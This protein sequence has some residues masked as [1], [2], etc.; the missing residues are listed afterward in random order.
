VGAATAQLIGL[1]GKRKSGTRGHSSTLTQIGK[2]ASGAVL[3]AIAMN[4]VSE[5]LA[6]HKNSHRYYRD[7]SFSTPR[8]SQIKTLA[9]IGVGAVVIASVFGLGQTHSEK[10][11]GNSRI[12]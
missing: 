6:R 1:R 3:G 12:N 5:H 11:K 10:N 8:N 9:G 7:T 2:H 4:A